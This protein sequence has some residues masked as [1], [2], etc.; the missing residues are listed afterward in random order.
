[1]KKVSYKRFRTFGKWKTTSSLKVLEREIDKLGIGDALDIMFHCN[2]K[3]T[4]N[5]RGIK[6]CKDCGT[7]LEVTSYRD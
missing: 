5:D 3:K 2:H 4:W 1:M 7:Q 6:T